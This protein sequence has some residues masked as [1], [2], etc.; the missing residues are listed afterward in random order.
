M[1]LKFLWPLL[2]VWRLIVVIGT[3]RVVVPFSF[4]VLGLPEVISIGWVGR[5]LAT[6]VISVTTPDLLLETRT[7]ICPI[8]VRCRSGCFVF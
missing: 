3:F 4:V 8:R 7:V 6:S 5:L 1:V 2:K